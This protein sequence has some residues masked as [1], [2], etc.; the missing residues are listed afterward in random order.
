MNTNENNV[1]RFCNLFLRGQ[2]RR[3]MVI[4]V[5][6]TFQVFTSIKNLSKIC[7][8]SRFYSL[9]AMPA[10]MTTIW[11]LLLLVS[12][13]IFY[14][15]NCTSLERIEQRPIVP[16][17]LKDLEMRVLLRPIYIIATSIT[18]TC[19][20]LSIPWPESSSYQA[21]YYAYVQ[22]TMGNWLAEVIQLTL[23]YTYSL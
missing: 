22:Q 6:V 3:D 12:S 13:H 9:A 7:M 18:A 21:T 16:I 4:Y 1:F 8:R 19:K 5:M 10:M 2:G 20:Q 11:A 23:A 14:C 15:Y 17:P